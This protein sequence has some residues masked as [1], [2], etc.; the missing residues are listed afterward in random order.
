VLEEAGERSSRL[1]AERS[2]SIAANRGFWK[3]RALGPA[4]LELRNEHHGKVA[5][6]I[7]KEDVC[8]RTAARALRS[9]TNSSIVAR[10]AFRAPARLPGFVMLS[11]TAGSALAPANHRRLESLLGCIGDL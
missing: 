10:N 3:R 6:A 2:C 4:V 9:R 11:G 1:H 5:R 7:K 8:N